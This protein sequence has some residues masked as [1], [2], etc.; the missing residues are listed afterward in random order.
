MALDLFYCQLGSRLLYP[1]AAPTTFA[2]LIL[3]KFLSAHLQLTVIHSYRL[4][5][6]FGIVFQLRLFQQSLLALFFIYLISFTPL[7]L[8]PLASHTDSSFTCVSPLLLYIL[9][10]IPSISLRAIGL[11]L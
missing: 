4:P 8:F 2:P 5:A 3:L 6:F 11:S 7:M 1:T 10:E 9:K